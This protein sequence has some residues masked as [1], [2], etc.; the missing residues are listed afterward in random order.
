MTKQEKPQAKLNAESQSRE[1][2]DSIMRELETK[3]LG[4]RASYKQQSLD[5]QKKIEQPVQIS[6][7][8]I[9]EQN[10]TFEINTSPYNNNFLDNHNLH[11]HN[12]TL[13]INSTLLHR[14]THQD[15]ICL[16][17]IN[18]IDT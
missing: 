4:E 13:N 10:L 16:G 2:L 8:N 12:E 6:R 11:L 7:L 1:N 3:L 9:N 15:R 5:L 18:Q 17:S 14:Q